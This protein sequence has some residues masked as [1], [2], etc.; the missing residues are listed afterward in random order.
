MTTVIYD[1]DNIFAPRPSCSTAD[2]APPELEPYIPPV[3][4]LEAYNPAEVQ[5]PE[6]YD[7]G[8]VKSLMR[9]SID[10]FGS[11]VAPDYVIYMFP[12][13]YTFLWGKITAAFHRNRDFSKFAIGL[14]R[15]HAKTFVV[16]LILLYAIMFTN[17]RYII[18]AGAN[19]DK[20]ADI[21]A[22]VY[23]MLQHPNIL[24]LFGNFTHTLDKD[25]QTL[26]KFSFNGRKITLEAVGQGTA[27]RGSSKNNDRPDLIVC[28][29]S[30][31]RKG[32]ES[33]PESQE[34]H[35][36]FTGDLMKAKSPFGC[37]YIY[38]GNMYKDL[39]LDVDKPGVYCCMLRN[40]QQ[41]PE[42]LSMIVGAILVDG[43]A[44]WEELQPLDQLLSEFASDDRLGQGDVFCAEVLNDP[45]G[46][47]AND[48]DA[49]KLVVFTKTPDMMHQGN[50]IVI[51]PSTSK[52]T[53]DQTVLGYY[54]I[55]DNH[56]V[57]MEMTVG[58]FTGPEQAHLAI[59]MALRN[60]CT[61]ICP[62]SI[63][64]Q[65]TLGEW[66]QYTAEQRGIHGIMVEPVPHRHGSKNSDIL[67]FFQSC[68]KGEFWVTEKTKSPI[69]AQAMLYDAKRTDNVDD[70]IDMGA[71]GMKVSLTMRHLMHIEHFPGEN[72]YPIDLPPVQDSSGF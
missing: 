59:D 55:F 40:L 45:L 72:D 54:E 42:W 15:G 44:L 65:H 31:T 69:I 35:K 32:A 10:V 5:G 19:V 29:D 18:V 36:W 53:P 46:R 8:E 50:F 11:I 26:K 16:K 43:T 39:K 24:K 7:S 70:I 58:K 66:I 57:C 34:Y 3:E 25:T 20:A 68:K 13:F 1:E 52:Q 51:D 41:D 56:P 27:V 6:F 63:A 17:K 9:E 23:K 67:R 49:S 38:I 64:Y 22:D 14:P 47:P 61:L 12:L 30:Q 21:I 71:M 62:E 37:T 48:F 4:E 60:Q 33:I 2:S 28:D